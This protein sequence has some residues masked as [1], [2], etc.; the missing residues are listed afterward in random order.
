MVIASA[1]DGIYLDLSKQQEVDL[2][3]KF[4]IGSIKEIIHDEDDGVFYILANKYEEKLG[5]F[6]IKMNADNPDE[7]RFLTKYKNKL[8]IGDCSIKVMRD[9]DFGFKE[10]VISYKT[11]YINTYN[12]H[13]LDITQE[14]QPTI[15]RH[16]S[17]QLWESESRGVLLKNAS[18]FLKLSKNGAEILGLG[19]VP[20]RKVKDR[21]IVHSL[22]SVNYLKIDPDNF[23]LFECADQTRIIS[24][25]QE[26][27]RH[28]AESGEETQFERIYSIKISEITLR[29]LLLFCSLYISATQ[30]DIVALVRDQP[31]PSVFYKSF[32]EFDGANMVSILSFDSRSMT[33]LLSD[34]NAK[35]FNDEFPIFYKN[36]IARRH[37]K[38]GSEY[39]YHSAIDRALKANQVRAVQTMIEYITKYQNNY[40]SSYLFKN[41]IDDL[42]ERGVPL[43]PLFD[44]NLFNMTI[45]YDEWPSSHT[46]KERY[47]RPYNGSIFQIRHDYSKI[48]AGQDFEAKHH[49]NRE[50]EVDTT[51]VYKIRYSINLLPQIG[52]HIEDTPEGPELVDEDENIMKILSGSEELDVYDTKSVQQLIEFK[53]ESHA[54][55]LHRFGC[56][57]HLIYLLILTIYINIVYIENI[58]DEREIGLLSVFLI[59]GI[60]YPWAYDTV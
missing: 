11:I 38:D 55:L 47:L 1:E 33:A 12:V 16:E 44:S 14:G 34:E 20:K 52:E 51:K 59:L 57:M 2:D 53:W 50:G 41:N 23:V 17:F 27:S 24:I 7:H 45:D 6:L 4:K 22:E 5:F 49:H 43:T 29:E 46:N 15:F 39:F 42:Q 48:F 32:L 18:D 8:D 31:N 25:V 40:V 56:Y 9:I 13:V 35:Y 54:S 10:L 26:Y 28:D 3:E 30:S 36:K 58:A 21:Q 60:A 37:Q 19:R